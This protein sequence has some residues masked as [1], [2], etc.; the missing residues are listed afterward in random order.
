MNYCYAILSVVRLINV[1]V[2][3]T[4]LKKRQSIVSNNQFLPKVYLRCL[5]YF[6]LIL[7]AKFLLIK[8]TVDDVSINALTAQSFI[9]LHRISSCLKLLMTKH[10]THPVKLCN[11]TLFSKVLVII[12]P[13]KHLHCFI[14]FVYHLNSRVIDDAVI[15]KVKNFQIFFFYNL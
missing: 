2:R 8:F 14:D 9:A 1:I 5:V 10:I 12:L 11:K 3:L 13:K 6:I 7:P 15:T 4:V